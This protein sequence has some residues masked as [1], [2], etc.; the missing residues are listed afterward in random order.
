MEAM[1]ILAQ[2]VLVM[3]ISRKLMP[4]G[5]IIFGVVMG[6]LASANIRNRK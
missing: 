2:T 1:D 5:M 4:L 3:A 6:L